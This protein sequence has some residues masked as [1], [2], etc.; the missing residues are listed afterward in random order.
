MACIDCEKFSTREC[1][2]LRDNDEDCHF[3]PRN[4]EATVF[5]VMTDNGTFWGV[6]GTYRD[7]KARIKSEAERFGKRLYMTDNDYHFL[8]TDNT[9]GLFDTDFGVRITE[10][11]IKL[12]Y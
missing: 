10:E 9:R 6:F 8:L 7:A 11:K 12:G 5:V 4:N 3:V 1:I 2:C